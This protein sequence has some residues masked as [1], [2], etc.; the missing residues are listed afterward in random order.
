[1]RRL[2]LAFLLPLTL[3]SLACSS[4]PFVPTGALAGKVGLTGIEPQAGINVTAAGP[5]SAT[6]TTDASG[7]Y[8]FS[9][10]P[11]GVYS[12]SASVPSTAEGEATVAV[13]LGVGLSSAPDLVFT[14]VGSV[15]GTVTL[16]LAAPS[17]GLAVTIDGAV[18]AATVTDA[19]GAYAF[20]GLPLGDYQ[21]TVTESS[22]MEG[23]A[24]VPVRVS[25]GPTTALPLYLWPLGT[26]SGNVFMMG[27]PP[28]AGLPVDLRWAPDGPVVA[29]TT[30]SVLG[31]YTFGRLRLA[32]Y[33]VSAT[34]P[35]TAEGSQTV[36]VRVPFGYSKVPDIVFTPVGA[37]GGAVT[38]AGRAPGAAGA[39]VWI[40]GTNRATVTDGA[41]NY[42][43]QGVPPGSYSVRASHVGYQTA[44][45]TGLAVAYATT[46]TAPGFDLS[47]TTLGTIATGRLSGY[48]SVVGLGRGAGIT[49]SV[50]GTA[51]STVTGADGSWTIDGVADGLWTLTLS[52]GLGV[53]H[54]PGVISLPGSQ[55]FLFDEVLYPIGEI[56]LQHAPRVSKTWGTRQLTNDRHL[57]VL[58]GTDLLSA[59]IDGGPVVRIASDVFRFVLPVSVKPGVQSWVAVVSTSGMVSA[60]PAAGGATVP[61]AV[62]RLLEFDSTGGVLLTLGADGRLWY[63][64]L[65]RA[66]VRPVATGWRTGGGLGAEY[67][68][69]LDP[70]TNT[71]GTVEWATGNVAMLA[72][73]IVGFNMLPGGSRLLVKKRGLSFGLYGDVLIGPPTGPLTLVA[74]TT[75]KI[76]N[77]SETWSPDGRWV[78]VSTIDLTTVKSSLVLASAVDGV[79]VRTEVGASFSAWS[80]DSSH[81]VWV[82][83]SSAG[84]GGYYLAAT[85]DGTSRVLN[86]QYPETFLFSPTG[87]YLAFLDGVQVRVIETATSTEIA[88]SP[89]MTR[90]SKPIVFSPDSAYVVVAGTSLHSLSTTGG[91][92]AL[93]TS[94]YIDG[95]AQ[96]SSDGRWVLFGSNEGLSSAPISGT[97]VRLL[98][99]PGLTWGG[100]LIVAPTNAVVFQSFPDFWF[101]PIEGGVLQSLG[102]TAP[103]GSWPSISPDGRTIAYL[104][105]DG[106]LVSA[107]LPGGTLITVATGVQGFQ[108]FEGGLVIRDNTGGFSVASPTGQARLVSDSVGAYAQAPGGRVVFTD[109]SRRLVAADIGT[110]LTTLL[111][112]GLDD[113]FWIGRTLRGNRTLF[114][115]GHV[116]RS[117]PV[118]GGPLTSH[119]RME[120]GGSFEWIDDQHAVV[121]RTNAPRPYRFQNGLYLV[122]VP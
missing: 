41:G 39:V 7:G 11:V 5:V 103:F 116:V 81:F 96:F 83:S 47:P 112:G 78:V 6:T 72:S 98:T 15:A 16:L 76:L 28:R 74:P 37:I 119:V 18:S 22:T 23:S 67:F 25:W 97:P 95:S 79:V 87:K 75:S 45:A 88:S 24:T 20:S 69:F 27:M 73:D 85:A 4:K 121:A 90:S 111:A 57:L 62:S 52:D 42:V 59:P 12:V 104:E 21:V 3:S 34:V 50:D 93:L 14:P 53:E 1:M 68:P 117:I 31:E 40:D 48:A 99:P 86:T 80:P 92:P 17:A 46:T 122:T 84:G 60:V 113:P 110:G 30:T 26:I 101:V 55:G 71:F 102:P 115:A 32:D 44:T 65:D 29:S 8:F 13:H 108:M 56:E 106:T 43:L 36:T 114:S 118:S 70:S 77:M 105:P 9:A 89:S 49:V 91:A 38:L 10:L 109:G 35:S 94:S 82:G 66:E 54:V 107:T 51:L 58:D 33:L 2:V 100:K 63:A 120:T 61:I 64:A 19:S